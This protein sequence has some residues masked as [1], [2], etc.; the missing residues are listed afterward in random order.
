[1]G[2]AN[3]N[4]RDISDLDKKP[5]IVIPGSEYK[6]DKGTKFDPLY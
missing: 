6:N 2:T 4:C 1:M 3:S 5:D